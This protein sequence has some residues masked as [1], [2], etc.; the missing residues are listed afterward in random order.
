MRI[1]I[2][3]QNIFTS[4]FNATSKT[5]AI[6]GVVEFQPNVIANS[7]G[8][9]VEVFDVTQGFDI[10]LTNVTVAKTKVAGLPV[11]TFTFPTLPAGV[12]TGDTLLVFFEL[13]LPT[14]MYTVAKYSASK[15]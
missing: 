11:W 7:P 12:V 8:S 9:L 15:V 13:D 4:T 10:P 14:A 5:L 1:I 3:K 2:G 6:S